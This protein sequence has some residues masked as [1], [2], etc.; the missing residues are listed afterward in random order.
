MGGGLLSQ[1]QLTSAAFSL[2]CVCFL[3]LQALNLPLR[4]SHLLLKTQ[5]S[6]LAPLLRLCHLLLAAGQLDLH[7][8]EV[9]LNGDALLLLL[10]GCVLAAGQLGLHG[11]EVCLKAHALPLL[12]CSCILAAGQLST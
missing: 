6:S 2:C 3:S 7:G 9:C 10:Y 4:G 5:L 1:A 8:T 12:L 11:T